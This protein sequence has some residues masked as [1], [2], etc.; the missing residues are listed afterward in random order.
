MKRIA[1][2]IILATMVIASSNLL[3]AKPMDRKGQK[4][5]PQMGQMGGMHQDGMRGH[6]NPMMHDMMLKEIGVSNENRAKIREI[7]FKMQKEMLELRHQIHE[8]MIAIHEEMGKANL[9]TGVIEK[10]NNAIAELKKQ[11]QLKKGQTMLE[12]VKILTPEQRIKLQQQMMMRGKMKNTPPN[13]DQETDH[14]QH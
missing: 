2:Y 6:K 14:S 11:K 10:H 9:D 8:K 13:K 3:T 1:T 7:H 5:K 4:G 12:I